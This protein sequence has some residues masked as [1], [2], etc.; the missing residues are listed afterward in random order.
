MKD[1]G[2]YNVRMTRRRRKRVRWG[3]FIIFILLLG[4]LMAAFCWITYSTF[5]VVNDSY[6]KYKTMFDDF[7]R[8]KLLHDKF[9]DEKYT[10]YTNI[11]ILGIDDGDPSMEDSP[12]RADTVM[13]AVVNHMTGEL[14]IL[15]IPPD[16]KMHLPGRKVFSKAKESYYFGQMQLAVR[17]VEE[18]LQLPV[19]HFVVIDCETFRKF[20]DAIGGIDIF[21]EQDMRYEDPEAGLT[22]S[23]DSGFQHLDGWQ[24]EQ[25]IRYNDKELGDVGRLQ[26]QQKLLRQ[27]H[28][29]KLNLNLLDSVMPI[30]D[31]MTENVETSMAVVDMLRV[32][33]VFIRNDFEKINI[34]M[35]PG[36]FST[37]DDTTYWEPDQAEIQIMVQ[38]I[39]AGQGN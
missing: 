21:V 13:V 15:S 29:D 16:T 4:S 35:I 6:V 25:Y 17:S 28:K 34:E 7:E 18:L 37:V 30:Y 26:R 9:N 10:N 23:L 11:L 33:W 5:L 1:R 12:R 8:R 3:R 32:G 31:V 38:G 14:S 36:K 20:I 22:I 2:K 24:A 27:L 39:F 19:H